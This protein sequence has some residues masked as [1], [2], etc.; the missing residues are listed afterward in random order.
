LHRTIFSQ[1]FSQEGFIPTFAAAAG[2]T[3]LVT[4]CAT[5]CKLGD[6]SF[7]NHLDG[8][9]LMPFFKGPLRE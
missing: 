7:H 5:T 6:R 8:Y 2:N 9:N 4:Q 3:G 1:F